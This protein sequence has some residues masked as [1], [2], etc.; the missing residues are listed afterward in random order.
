MRPSLSRAA[1]ITTA[2]MLAVAGC[3]ETSPIVSHADL[4]KLDVGNY[5]AQ[6][7]NVRNEPSLPQGTMLEGI[8]MSDGVADSS[9]FDSLLLYLWQADPVPDTASL[10]QLL[11]EGGRQVLDQYG[12]VAGYRAGYADRPQLENRTA[13]SVF[14]GI[15]ILLLRFPDDASAR[16]AA[17]ALEPISWKDFGKTVPLPLPKHPEVVARYTPGTGALIADAAVG[18]FVVHLILEAPPNGI[19]T[20]VGSLDPVLD[21]E[22]TLLRDFKPTPVSDIAALPVDPDGLLA[23]M[24]TTD[25]VNQPPVTGTFA[26]YGATGGL[27]DQPP[28]FRKDGLYEKWGVDRIGVTAE[29]H[30]YRLRDHQA[31]MDMMEA[32]IADSSGREHEIE[33]DKNVPDEHCFETAQPPPNAPAFACRIVFDRF[34]TLVRGD[35]AI[36]AKQKAAA[37]YKL[38]AENP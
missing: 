31:A 20:H 3:A 11:G 18:P 8:R 35:T 34:Y 27:R 23:R 19:E 28:K 14:I 22:H 4:T 32:F 38:L 16:G 29:Q 9:Q 10:V 7:R 17:S 36:S 25:P 26:V 5:S 13:P 21:A 2:A 37:Q 1:A 30:L 15:S 24:V 33:A 12:W 6:L